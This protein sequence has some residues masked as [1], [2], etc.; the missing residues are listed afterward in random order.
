MPALDPGSARLIEDLYLPGTN[1]RLRKVTAP[2][3]A[4]TCK[5]GKKYPGAGLS[6][7]PMTNIYLDTA[8]YGA[9]AALPAASLVKRRF[10]VD[11][12]FAIDMFEGSLAGLILAE[13]SADDDATLIAIKA[14]VWCTIEVTDDRAYAGGTLAIEGWHGKAPP[15]VPGMEGDEA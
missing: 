8:E 4:V 15:C 13:V 1:L 12:G 3:G 7:R 2:D 5:L 14:P 9:L 6:S 11:D 10:D